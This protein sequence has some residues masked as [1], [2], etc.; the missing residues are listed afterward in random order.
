[1]RSAVENRS[2]SR[3]IALVGG[4][5]LV[6]LTG[7]AGAAYATDNGPGGEP[8]PCAWAESYPP[9]LAQCPPIPAGPSDGNVVTSDSGPAT[10]DDGNS[11]DGPVD[12][13]PYGVQAGSAGPGDSAPVGEGEPAAGSTGGDPSVG[14]GVLSSGPDTVLSPDLLDVPAMPEPTD[15]HPGPVGSDLHHDVVRSAR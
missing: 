6:L 8:D 13:A 10:R 15:D 14:T 3:R 7:A 9:Q 2:T 12:R 5:L 1:M 11:G 4:A